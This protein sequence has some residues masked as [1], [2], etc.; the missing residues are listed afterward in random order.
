[1]VSYLNLLPLYE[2]FA[3]GDHPHTVYITVA[4]VP[5]ILIDA[6]TN[7]KGDLTTNFVDDVTIFLK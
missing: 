1:M 5:A 2:E 7:I 6:D 4:K 3:R